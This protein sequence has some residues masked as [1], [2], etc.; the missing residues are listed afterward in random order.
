MNRVLRLFYKICS[1]LP[2]HACN[3]NTSFSKVHAVGL[4]GD[5]GAGIGERDNVLDK[6]DIISGTLG[7]AV[8]VIGGY[9]AGSSALIDT[10]RRYVNLFES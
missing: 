5:R 2:S 4:Y 9:I 1:F 6:M 10:I 7:K 8:G 3:H